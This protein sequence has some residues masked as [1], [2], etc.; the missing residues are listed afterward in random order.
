LF[1][2]LPYTEFETLEPV[3]YH[4]Q[5][6][7]VANSDNLSYQKAEDMKVKV[8]AISILPNNKRIEVTVGDKEGEERTLHTYNEK[9]KD[10]LKI[11]A[12][13]QLDRLKYEGYTGDFMGYG[14]PYPKHSG[15]VSIYDDRYIE[16]R[17]VSY[18]VDKVTTT[19]GKGGFRRKIEIGKRV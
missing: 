9:D 8:K 6:N 19:W 14:V 7:I 12:E 4:F 2:G 15:A 13:S 3:R 16:R 10:K 1:V 11:W 5:R 18:V 17:N